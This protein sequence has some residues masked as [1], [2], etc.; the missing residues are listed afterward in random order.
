M[1]GPRK[2]PITAAQIMAFAVHSAQTIP[3]EG[4]GIRETAMAQGFADDVTDDI[5][6]EAARQLGHAQNGLIDVTVAVNYELSRR[7][8]MRRLTAELTA[9]KADA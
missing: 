6:I 3:G 5:L 2:Q 4:H 9:A 8:D 1:A 7:A